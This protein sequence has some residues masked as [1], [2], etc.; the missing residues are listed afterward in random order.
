[1]PPMFPPEETQSLPPHV[2]EHVG[3]YEKHLPF[4]ATILAGVGAGMQKQVSNVSPLR[5][6]GWVGGGLVSSTPSFRGL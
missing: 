6:L 5:L 4:L 2:Q 3:L 1:M